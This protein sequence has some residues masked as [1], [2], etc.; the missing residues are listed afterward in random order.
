MLE[1]G[2]YYIIN[3]SVKRKKVNDNRGDLSMFVGVFHHNI[4]T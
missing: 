3:I 2:N 1:Q 4:P